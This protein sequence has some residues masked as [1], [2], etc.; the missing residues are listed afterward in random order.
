M[1]ASP[2]DTL[3]S[4]EVLDIL[5]D[6]EARM[7]RLRPEMEE[8]KATY[9]TRYW[10]YAQRALSLRD[11]QQQN[12]GQENVEV[13]RLW[14]GVES[15]VSQLYPHARRTVLSPDEDGRG[16]PL[17]AQACLNAWWRKE[18]T[19]AR[20]LAHLRQALLYPGSGLTMEVRPGRG[21][22]IQRVE[23][24]VTPYWEMLL[25]VDVFD[26]KHQR[27]RGRRYWIPVR[28]AIAAWP[29][30]KQ[31]G[32]QGRV[33]DEFL[34]PSM[35][36][37]IEGQVGASVGTHENGSNVISSQYAKSPVGDNDTRASWVEVVEFVNLVDGF[38]DSLG[39]SQGRF[40]V[41]L[42]GQSG[43][44]ESEPLITSRVP[45]A[46]SDGVPL[47]HVVPTLLA[48][49][50]EYPL[51]GIPPLRRVMPQQRELNIMR[52]EVLKRVRQNVDKIIT[53][54]GVWGSEARQQLAS[55]VNLE[56]IKLDTDDDI[57]STV[58]QLSTAP[59]GPDLRMYAEVVE[60]DLN[61]VMSLSSNR[62]GQQNKGATA[63]EVQSINM[64]DDADM[65]KH[66]T[67]LES[68]CSDLSR[69]ALAGFILAAQSPSDH[70]SGYVSLQLG[71]KVAATAI[72]EGGATQVPPVVDV[73]AA[74]TAD[75]EK[76][77][78]MG[79]DPAVLALVRG[80]PPEGTPVV[81]EASMSEGMVQTT[82]AV[83]SQVWSV[84]DPENGKSTQVDA[85]KLDGNFTITFVEGAETP[86]TAQAQQ[87]NLVA[88]QENYMTLWDIVQ[89]GGPMAVLAR[90]Y[91]VALHD[92]LKLPKDLHP[93]R[94]QEAV[95]AQA[96]EAPPPAP[97]G[98]PAE[99]PSAPGT[100]AKNTGPAP[101]PPPS[102]GEGTQKLI[103]A[104][105][106][107]AAEAGQ[108]GAPEVAAAI[109]K[110][111]ESVKTG[112]VSGAVISMDEAYT[113]AS[114]GGHVDLEGKLGPIKGLMDQAA[115]AMLA[116]EQPTEDPN[117]PV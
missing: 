9:L 39:V 106:A 97:A 91:M 16:D 31:I 115:E 8:H 18:G 71:Q 1:D 21:S 110:V 6:Q 95:D 46:D 80:P 63:Y 56:M 23:F 52:S 85:D 75:A 13:N 22:P 24:A 2:N 89:K 12:Q 49:E 74:A 62:M 79:V 7:L 40:E 17:I 4:Q 66:A 100:A 25:D 43:R 88:V 42:R 81:T 55:G 37:S 45:F 111:A 104:L 51:R 90:R 70:R 108:T 41:Y 102:Q 27:F 105:E 98:V 11:G 32:V 107:L 96:K 76:T 86:Q 28:Q 57:R 109:G 53:K 47:P 60:R 26:A 116:E 15:H 20:I 3:R 87:Q 112:D 68:T 34:R 93:D 59:L 67:T 5:S 30:L 114:M 14:S 44:L 73:A 117:A 33:R 69:L 29:Q 54:A 99:P 72:V 48:F 38:E 84:L 36:G 82:V 83:P 78:S 113:L 65:R 61:V 58:L 77:A 92:K 94:L 101:G 64:F 10:S 103:A 50:P 35:S 19:L